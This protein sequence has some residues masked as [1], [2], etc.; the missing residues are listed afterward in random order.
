MAS[1][2]HTDRLMDLLYGE[3]SPD[4]EVELRAELG[5]DFSEDELEDYRGLLDEVRA[6]MPSQDVSASVHAS[7]MEAAQAGLSQPAERP[8]REGRA[9]SGGFWKRLSGGQGAQIALVAAVLLVGVFVARFVRMD[10]NQLDFQKGAEAPA[11]EVVA[12]QMEAAPAA[13]AGSVEVAEV[14]D[15][16]VAAKLADEVATGDEPEVATVTPEAEEPAQDRGSDAV[17][18]GEQRQNEEQNRREFA[19]DSKA[20]EAKPLDVGSTRSPKAKRKKSLGSKSSSKKD[21]S[22]DGAL[23]LFGEPSSDKGGGPSNQAP[24]VVAATEEVA[25][26]A[27][28]AGL[29]ADEEPAKEP[30][31]Q[32]AEQKAEYRPPAGSISAVDQRFRA[33][34]YDGTIRAADAFLE[35]GSGSQIERARALHLKAQALSNLGRYA[36]ADRVYG[37]IQRN[38]PNYQTS[39]INAAREEVQRRLSKRQPRKKQRVKPAEKSYDAPSAADSMD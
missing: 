17:W 27:S 35:D 4:E 3:L 37:S 18:G 16:N 1:E 11:R 8:V 19:A 9:D 7:I 32:P 10:D 30:A 33:N 36:E 38:Y 31:A 14:V 5:D 39:E 25:E 20:K 12:A 23:N 29:D 13:P 28:V 21:G 24:P 6:V 22:L 34:D 26:G 15:S 2:Q